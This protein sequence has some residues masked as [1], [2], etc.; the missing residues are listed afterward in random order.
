MNRGMNMSAIATM[1]EQIAELKSDF[2]FYKDEGLN[3]DQIL[4][5]LVNSTYMHQDIVSE[6]V[7]M[8]ATG[9]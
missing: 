5:I 6:N 7:M 1:G 4:K 8:W 2:D 3:A 9:N